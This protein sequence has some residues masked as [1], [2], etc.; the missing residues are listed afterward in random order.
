MEYLCG[1]V[2]GMHTETGGQEIYRQQCME[3]IPWLQG[4]IFL[5][6][7]FS[8]LTSQRE[9][10]FFPSYCLEG[11]FARLV[12]NINS[13]ECMYWRRQ[14]L[15]IYS[16]RR[17]VLAVHRHLLGLPPG[18]P[19]LLLCVP[20]ITACSLCFKTAGYWLGCSSLVTTLELYSYSGMDMCLFLV[21]AGVLVCTSPSCTGCLLYTSDAADE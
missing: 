12:R 11:F 10:G 13:N 9:F 8:L 17:Q 21:A 16:S 18:D 1:V 5:I 6:L 4:H 3:P 19:S 15:E 20:A 7:L 14:S 2:A